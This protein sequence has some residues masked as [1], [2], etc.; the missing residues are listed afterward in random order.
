MLTSYF[1]LLLIMGF[2]VEDR[3]WWNVKTH[4]LVIVLTEPKNMLIYNTVFYCD[5]FSSFILVAECEI[6][7]FADVGR[8]MRTASL[9]GWWLAHYQSNGLIR[10]VV[11]VL[12]FK[13]CKI[14]SDNT[15]TI[16]C[17]YQPSIVCVLSEN[18]LHKL[19]AQ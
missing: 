17:C 10:P 15:Q 7:N 8:C 14:F 13:L 18:I 1:L 3:H 16:E 9:H 5:L 4:Q 19:V 2:T 6:L 11:S 12:L